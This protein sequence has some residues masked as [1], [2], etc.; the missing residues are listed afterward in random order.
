MDPQLFLWLATRATGL[1]AYIALCVTVLSGIALRTSVLDWLAKNRAMRALHDWTAWLW[2]PL[3]ALHVLTLVFEKAARIGLADLV[4][5]FR[6]DY[7]TVAIGLGTLSLDLL[8]VITVTSWMRRRMNDA[9]WRWIHRTSYLMFVLVFLHSSLSGTDFS[10]PLVSAI[11]WS[12]AGALA[13][14]AASRIVF[15]RLPE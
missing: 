8:V 4:V 14:L 9:L 7:G 11:S 5:P 3:G 12:V 1:A 2:I 10:A 13:L 15:G 6:V